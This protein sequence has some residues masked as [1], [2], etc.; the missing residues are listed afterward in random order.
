MADLATHAHEE[1]CYLTTTGR[2]SG[3]SHTVEIWFVFHEGAFFLLSGAGG[4]ADW[5]QNL[6]ARSTARLRIG[7]DEAEV[8][9]DEPQ[10]DDTVQAE[11]R[12][13]LRE[14]YAYEGDDLVHWA[15]E[16]LLVRL[17]PV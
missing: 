13:L 10:P 9:G 5:V 17:I 3:A 1:L 7:D 15:N 12:H 4:G 6:R 11:A 16:S 8:T 2:S 14:K